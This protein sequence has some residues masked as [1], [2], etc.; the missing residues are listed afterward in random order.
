MRVNRSAIVECRTS[1]VDR[2]CGRRNFCAA[3]IWFCSGLIV[4]APVCLVAAQHTLEDVAAGLRARD[5]ATRLRAVQILRDA[6]YPE[7]AGPLSA[8]VNDPDDRVEVAAIAAERSRFTT[9][10]LARR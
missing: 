10:P 5:V 8:A 1:I 7:A 6:G 9:S 2:R 4:T 3:F